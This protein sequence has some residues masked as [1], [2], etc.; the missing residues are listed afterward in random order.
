MN[1]LN[2]AY[3]AAALKRADISFFYGGLLPMAPNNAHHGDVRLVKHYTLC[4]HRQ[5][6]GLEGLVTVVGVK[7]TTAR[8]VA[9]KAIDLIFKKLG[10]QPPRCCTHETP[11]HGG[12]IRR[13]EE[14]VQR[15]T[16]QRPHGLSAEIVKP[17]VYNYG[18][19]YHEVLKYIGLDPDAVQPIAADSNIL[20][21][22]VLYNIREEMAQKLADVIRR[23]TELGSAGYPGD[24]AVQ[25]CATIMAAELGWDAAKIQNE[26]REV[27][28]IYSTA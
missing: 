14:F 3:P 2:A 22:E 1:E 10:H 16:S 17:L 6:D 13:F 15:E 23:R 18:S 28:A 7:Y 4:D 25:A 12:D 8:D 21:A 11:V 19:A 24:E 26:I 5:E 20:R 9:E 27:K